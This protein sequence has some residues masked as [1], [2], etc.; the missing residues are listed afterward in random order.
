MNGYRKI[1]SLIIFGLSSILIS[2]SHNLPIAPKNGSYDQMQADLQNGVAQDK[3]LS[4]KQQT[5]VPSAVRNALIPSVSTRNIAAVT[6]SEHR[7]DVSADK[8]PAKSFFMG[9]VEGTSYN[10]V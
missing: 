10:M 6:E 9:L 2:C 5:Y 7:F 8:L 3:M 1:I 4:K